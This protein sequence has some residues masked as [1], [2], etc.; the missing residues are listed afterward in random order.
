MEIVD[1]V[2]NLKREFTIIVI[3]VIIKFHWN[4]ILVQHRHRK[5]IRSIDSRK[6]FSLTDRS[7]K[8]KLRE[9]SINPVLLLSPLPLIY[10]ISSLR[11]LKYLRGVV[12]LSLFLSPFFLSL[13]FLLSREKI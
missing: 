6:Q 1:Q 5:P 4:L 10:K 8:I 2:N 13:N 12:I 9:E 7:L 3:L 11:K